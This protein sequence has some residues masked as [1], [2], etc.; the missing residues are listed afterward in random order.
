MSITDPLAGMLT[1]VRKATSAPHD[2]VSNPTSR[3]NVPLIKLLREEGYIKHYK[4]VKT[5]LVRRNPGA[6]KRKPAAK[7]NR[8]GLIRIYLKYGPNRERVINGLKRVSRPGCRDYVGCDKIPEVFGG[9]GI[10]VM[11]T[12]KGVMSGKQARQERV[13]GELLAMVW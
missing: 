13:G 2:T 8:H 9:L 1:R 7:E 4:I 12:P 6:E 10:A 11:S 5:A 3:E